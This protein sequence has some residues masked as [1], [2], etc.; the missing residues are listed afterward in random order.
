MFRLSEM[1]EICK[2]ASPG[3][4]YCYTLGQVGARLEHLVKIRIANV[5]GNDDL[6]AMSC[7]RRKQ[8]ARFVAAARNALPDYITW[9]EKAAAL[10]VDMQYCC[11]SKRLAAEAQELI[12]AVGYTKHEEIAQSELPQKGDIDSK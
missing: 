4:W 6:T 3:P 7:G 11:D 5:F 9:A 12:E 2:E 10:L 1:R 8:N